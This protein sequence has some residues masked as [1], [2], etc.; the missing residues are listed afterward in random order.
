MFGL[1]SEKDDSKSE[2]L[3]DLER[4]VKNVD[5]YK[6]IID[7]IDQRTSVI[8]ELMRTGEK[9]EAFAKLAMVL[10]GYIAVLKVLARVV[11]KNA[12][13]K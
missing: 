6:E 4:D 2:F 5:R 3:F 7:T 9:K 11:S 1:G 13:K 10:H 8:K 12:Q